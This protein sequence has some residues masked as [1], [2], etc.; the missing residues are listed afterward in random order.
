MPEEAT[1][2]INP[3]IKTV[4]FGIRKLK[5]VTIYPLSVGHQRKISDGFADALGKFFG[6]KPEDA[7]VAMAGFA[8]RLVQDNLSQLLGFITD[9]EELQKLG[10]NSIRDFEDD[11]SNNQLAEIAETIVDVNYTNIVAKLQSSLLKILPLLM[12]GAEQVT[13]KAGQLVSMKQSS[14]SAGDS[15]DTDSNISTEGNT[16]REA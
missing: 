6:T 13:E 12:K 15:P 14:E 10:I 5:T 9:E 2:D 4:K 1:M 16:T 7:D 8:V 11:L 3:D